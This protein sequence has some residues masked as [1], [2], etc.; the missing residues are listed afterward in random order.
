MTLVIQISLRT[1]AVALV[2]FNSCPEDCLLH[3]I[4]SLD[5]NGALVSF[6]RE[7]PVF[8]KLLIGISCSGGS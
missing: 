4:S 8:G 6:A 3:C 7:V 5:V 1:I 2:Y